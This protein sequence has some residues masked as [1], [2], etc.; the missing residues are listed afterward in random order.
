MQKVIVNKIRCK[1]CGD[2]IE[3]KSKHDF[4]SCKCGAVA[5]DGGTDYLRRTFKDSPKDFEE[6]SVCEDV[7]DVIKK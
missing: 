7:S 6:L 5:I 3:S 4:K 1:K 2:I